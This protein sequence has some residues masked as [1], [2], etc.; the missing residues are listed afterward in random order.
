MVVSRR[1]DG[2][3]WVCFDGKDLNRAIKR[4]HH[5]TPTLEESTCKFSGAKFFS[6]M[7]AKYGY[8]SVDL[9]E[10]STELTTFTSVFGRYAYLKV[11]FGHVVSKD[12]FQQKMDQILEH[13]PRTVG[14]AD[15]V[16]VF[17]ATKEENDNNL[18]ILMEVTSKK[19]AVNESQIKYFGMICDEHRV[20]PD[21]EKVD[22]IKNMAKPEN[23]TK[24]QEFLGLATFLSVFIPKLMSPASALNSLLSLDAEYK[25]TAH[26]Q[27]VLQKIKD[28][29]C[30][31]A[32]LS[33]FDP[34]KATVIQVDV[35]S[36]GLGA[37]LMQDRKNHQVFLEIPF[38][39]DC[40]ESV[41]EH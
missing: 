6:K 27:Q 21:P 12:V 15:D 14:I 37:A 38:G 20:R 30:K 10:E 22:H 18:W 16:V 23:K 36:N 29:I 41:R 34:T 4:C 11:S 28:M 40:E 32:I 25:W 26:H 35:S 9:N 8:W 5:K 39:S 1:A 3:L 24:V 7:D 31:D 13:C 17:G 19:C 2:R 33:Y